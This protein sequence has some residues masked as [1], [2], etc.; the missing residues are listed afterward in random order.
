[1]KE[2]NIILRDIKNNMEV[3]KMSEMQWKEPINIED[4]KHTGE[5]VRVEERDEPFKYLDF[6]IKIQDQEDVEIKYGCPR[7]LSQSSKLGKLMEKF[8]FKYEK[9]AKIDPVKAMTGKQ[10]SFMTINETS[11]DG[12]DYARIVDGSIK[13]LVTTESVKKGV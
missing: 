4:G 8:A 13:P 2:N 6:Y 3:K 10:V 1:M 5:I 7:T 11:T 9:G 12:R